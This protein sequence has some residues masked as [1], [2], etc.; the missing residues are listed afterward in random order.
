MDDIKWRIKVFFRNLKRLIEYIPIIWN[1]YDF[2]YRYSTD[3]MIVQL[4]RLIKHLESDDAMSLNSKSTAKEIKLFIKLYERVYDEYYAIEYFDILKDKY[5]DIGIEDLFDTKFVDTD[6][7]NHKG[8]KL[9]E[10]K[11]NYE[12]L[13]DKDLVKEIDKTMD[14]EFKKAHQKQKKAERI[15]WN[16]FQHKHRGWWD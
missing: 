6:S 7:E 16:Y 5:N 15:L 12:F 9:Y 11:Y 10:M 1:T 3:L 14:I 13:D 2:D 8:Q 4:K